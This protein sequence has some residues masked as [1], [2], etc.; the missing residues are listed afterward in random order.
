MSSY[1]TDSKIVYTGSNDIISTGITVKNNALFSK[2]NLTDVRSSITQSSVISIPIWNSCITYSKTSNI[3]TVAGKASRDAYWS[4]DLG[5]N[6]TLSSN[7]FPAGA[8]VEG[9]AS[10]S[11]DDQGHWVAG[12][13]NDSGNVY[14]SSDGKTFGTSVSTGL[15][16]SYIQVT[17]IPSLGAFI[18]TSGGVS[19]NQIAFSYNGGTTWSISSG[20]F[21]VGGAD[22][23]VYGVAY[24][25]VTNT[26]VVI[27]YQSGVYYS[28]N[29]GTSWSLATD[30][31]GFVSAGV[32]S[33]TY[34]QDIDLFI[35]GGFGTV[36]GYIPVYVSKTGSTWTRY[37][38][39]ATSGLIT[40][41]CWSPVLKIFLASFN[42]SP[43]T[44]YY[45]G[46]GFTWTNYSLT[47]LVGTLNI[48]QIVYMDS[49]FIAVI[50]N[51]GSG[52]STRGVK[53]ITFPG[54]SPVS[55]VTQGDTN[56]TTQ[57][58]QGSNLVM[59][60][61]NLTINSKNINI[62]TSSALT[63]IYGLLKSSSINIIGQFLANGIPANC[64][65]M[66]STTTATPAG[67]PSGSG[68]TSL[69][70]FAS[71][72]NYGNV[73][74]L[75]ST[76]TQIHFNYTGMYCAYFNWSGTTASSGSYYVIVRQYT[77]GGA[78][79]TSG[80]QTIVTRGANLS[81][82]VTG[83]LTMTCN[84]TDYLSILLFVDSTQNNSI[85]ST[86][87]LGSLIVLRLPPNN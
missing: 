56:L 23:A 85:S 65:L 44:T 41:I 11:N 53:R 15:G 75:E 2:N 71:S 79:I 37:A 58:I 70:T 51:D 76:N 47:G 4:T 8:A 42:S 14:L 28:T 87:S 63:T 69:C 64:M 21:T 38:T 57:N 48:Y 18:A 25:V 31:T 39:P 10:I 74:T 13:W 5:V 33:I 16:G 59:D 49:S 55:T 34:S 66:A 83:S 84:S 32:R 73:F 19:P 50:G 67:I 3:L 82:T 45:S 61:N 22:K 7:S 43:V 52:G 6:W 86:N 36:S 1:R 9:V 77:S 27:T 62:G 46:N 40:S 30:P 78:V 35:I 72:T 17:Y 54:T 68:G 80:V 24:S 81:L 26:L 20:T 12:S 60:T 29:L